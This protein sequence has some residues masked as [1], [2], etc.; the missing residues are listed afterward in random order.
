MRLTFRGKQATNK[1]LAACLW[2]LCKISIII[3][4]LKTNLNVS[5]RLS[6]L[7]EVTQ[8]VRAGGRST[9]EF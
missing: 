1:S 6:N 7:P 8:Q 5:E 4:S 2:Q 9:S 3:F